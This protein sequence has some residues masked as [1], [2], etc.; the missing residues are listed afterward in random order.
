MSFLSRYWRHVERQHTETGMNIGDII[1]DLNEIIKENTDVVNA[2]EPST[3]NPQ[4]KPTIRPNQDGSMP[5]SNDVKF[6][7]G[8]ARPSQRVQDLAEDTRPTR[9]AKATRHSSDNA[10]RHGEE[11]TGRDKTKNTA[12]EV[13]KLRKKALKKLGAGRRV[14]VRLDKVVIDG[15]EYTSTSLCT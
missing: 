15:H 8:S 4:P 10:D 14:N 1:I 9:E 2:V 6:E 13:K 11:G 3:T 12:R 7:R 5:K